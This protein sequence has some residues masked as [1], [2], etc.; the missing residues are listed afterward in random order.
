[1]KPELKEY[2]S[3]RID[4]NINM[5]PAH[6]HQG[7]RDYV[8]NRLEPGGFLTAVLENDLKGAVG[9]A[10]NINRTHLAAWANFVVWALPSIC[11]GSPEK[12]QAYL[13]GEDLIT[14]ADT[15]EDW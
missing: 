5:I 7:V 10:D 1:M 12:V 2:L 9:R 15:P 6:M 8:F 3:K 13:R 4:E 11:H 14:A